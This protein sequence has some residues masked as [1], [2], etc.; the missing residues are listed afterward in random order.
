MEKV[1]RKCYSWRKQP[2]KP[3][4]SSLPVPYTQ[5]TT[6]LFIAQ[7]QSR[8]QAFKMKKKFHIRDTNMTDGNRWGEC[9][10]QQTTSVGKRIHVWN[11]TDNENDMGDNNAARHFE[12]WWG[13]ILQSYFISPKGK[14]ITGWERLFFYP[15]R[16]QKPRGEKEWSFGNFNNQTKLRRR[17]YR[18]VTV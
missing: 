14:W 1:T 16:K 3:V 6:I 2:R 8:R 13:M 7:Y 10:V 18:W 4:K 12:I 11:C 15:S 9:T 17:I 5:H